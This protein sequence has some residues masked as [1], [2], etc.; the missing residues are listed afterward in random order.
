MKN[1]CFPKVSLLFESPGF[2]VFFLFAGSRKSKYSVAS[3]MF[4]PQREMLLEERPYALVDDS[5]NYF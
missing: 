2:W 3:L 5:A 4:H 1:T